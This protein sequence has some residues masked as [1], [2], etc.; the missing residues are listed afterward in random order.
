[1]AAGDL[2]FT[3][4]NADEDG[5]T[6]VATAEL[7]ANSRIYF[8]DNEWNGS[9]AFNSG[10]GFHRWDAGNQSIAAGTVVRF[11]RIDSATQLAASV[12]Q[13]SRERVDGSS[14]FNLSQFGDTLY[15]YAGSSATTPTVFVTALSTAGFGRTEGTLQGTGLTA[16]ISATDLPASID[17]AAWSAARSGQT[18]PQFRQQIASAGNWQVSDGGNFALQAPDLST[19]NASPIPEPSA[20]VAAAAGLVTLQLLARRSAWR[21]QDNL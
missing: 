18:W 9:N 12:G 16:G 2:M 4:F 19:F 15:A 7:A 6:M 1:M 8:T 13:L 5:W 11:S 14:T 3:A 20:W 21:Q 17:L 10:E